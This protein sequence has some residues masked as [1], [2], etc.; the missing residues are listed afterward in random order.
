MNTNNEYKQLDKN[1]GLAFDNNSENPAAPKKKG[2]INVE[3]KVYKIAIWER[4]SKAGN[5]YL[6]FKLDPQTSVSE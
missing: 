3:G 4:K 2:T 1:T 6:Y 5:S